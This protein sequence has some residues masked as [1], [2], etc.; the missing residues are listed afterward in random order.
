LKMPEFSS[1]KEKA[2]EIIRDDHIMIARVNSERQVEELL[3]E[4]GQ[5]RLRTPLNIFIGGQ[6]L[7]RGLTIDNLIGFYYGRR[8]N[9]YQQDTVLQHSRMYGRRPKDDLAVTR[10]YTAR[11]IYDAMGRIYELDTALRLAFQQGAQN[12][13]VIFLQ[14]DS[15]NQIIPCS[16]NKILISTTTTLRPFKRML[17]VGFQTGYKSYIKKTIEITDTF[18]N[19]LI[20]KNDP[21]GPFLVDL[22]VAQKIL[23]DI[24]SVYEIDESI[25][26]GDG[27]K[28]MSAS[29]EFL[30]KNTGNHEHRGK[31]WC[32]VRKGRSISR[33]RETGE[34]FE[35]SPDT[36]KHEGV[37][38][39][40]A[41]IDIPIL[42]LF[43]QDGEEEKKWRGCP[44]W[45]P[46]LMAPQQTPTIIFANDTI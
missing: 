43:R 38:A 37:I 30:S 39:K 17:P 3:D 25:F 11:I 5:L 6:I 20:P 9:R 13:G 29:L 41:A 22:E 12:N 45:W 19:T 36:P 2:Y 1:V 7:D 32:L 10:F 46:V 21:E 4:S 35:N 8:P 34:R 31:V 18:I 24:F 27:L 16:P 44:F 33:F 42:M 40:Q 23:K 26:I 14:T 28:A 15:L